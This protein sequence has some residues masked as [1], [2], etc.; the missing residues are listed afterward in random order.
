MGAAIKTVHDNG[1]KMGDEAMNSVDSHVPQ[2]HFE[3]FDQELANAYPERVSAIR[4]RCPVAWSD[5]AWS[6][7]GSGFWLLTGF[8]NVSAAGQDWQ[9]FSS[10]Q[11]AAPVQFDL[12]VFRMVPLETDPP[13][14]REIRRVLSP[15]FAPEVLKSAEDVIRSLVRELLNGCIAESPCDFTE[16]F[17]V[18]VPSRIF[19]EI[20]LGEDPKEI[21]WMIE[22]I[23]TLFA[24]PESAFEKAPELLGW[25]AT[26][27]E[28]RRTEGRTDDVLGAIAHAGN[29]SDFELNEMDRIQTVFLL[30]LAGMETTASGLGNILHRLALNSELRISLRDLDTAQLNHAVDEFLRIDSP[31]PASG[32]TLTEDMELGGCPMKGGERVLLNWAAANRDPSVFTNPDQLELERSE[33]VKHV[34]FGSGPHRCL[35]S[36][37]ARREIRV[38][39]EEIAKLQTF[40]LVPGTEVTF[41]AGPA[42]GPASLPIICK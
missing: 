36:H 32:R 6:E 26:V 25:C 12:D 8:D 10:A 31:V 16:Q 28:A 40:E 5:A 29:E 21:A 22:T 35:G 9:H 2:E 4:D 27:L 18:A 38:V 24:H 41:R 11:G 33:S 15:F 1:G 17:T 13:I 7:K 37:L 19:F 39:L 20:F 3:P 34:A 42:R 30:I 23:K 14:H